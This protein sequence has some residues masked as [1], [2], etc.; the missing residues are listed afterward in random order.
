MD[1]ERV[2]LVLAC[3]FGESEISTEASQKF[4]SGHLC[5]GV[6]TN[7]SHAVHVL[8]RVSHLDKLTRCTPMHNKMQRDGESSILTYDSYDLWPGFGVGTPVFPR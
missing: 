6:D 1:T 8:P 2:I 4:P 3:M 5:L 7:P